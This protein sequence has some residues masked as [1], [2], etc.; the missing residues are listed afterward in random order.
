[1]SWTN[2]DVKEH[3]NTNDSLSIS[4]FMDK[5]T[6][7][8]EDKQIN[9]S[10]KLKNNEIIQLISMYSPKLEKLLDYINAYKFNFNDESKEHVKDKKPMTTSYDIYNRVELYQLLLAFNGLFSAYEFKYSS[11]PNEKISYPSI[12]LLTN[13]FSD[14]MKES[15]LKVIKKLM[16][17]EEI[18]RVTEM[19]NNSVNAQYEISSLLSDKLYMDTNE[20]NEILDNPCVN[21]YLA[22][23]L[24][25]S[26]DKNEL[27]KKLSSMFMSINRYI[28]ITN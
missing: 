17:Q 18:L 3:V 21:T 7:I 23:E 6:I 19:L 8:N 10:Y 2:P 27:N 25:N 14:A 9:S 20:I 22:N 11:N 13:I 26:N 24:S 12:S 28:P 16:S 4:A 1:M 5:F 15:N